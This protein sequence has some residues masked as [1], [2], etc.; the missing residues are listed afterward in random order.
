MKRNYNYLAQLLKSLGLQKMKVII[1]TTI[2]LL[3][4]SFIATFKNLDKGHWGLNV[5]TQACFTIF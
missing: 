4:R 2:I 3:S 5:A 1:I